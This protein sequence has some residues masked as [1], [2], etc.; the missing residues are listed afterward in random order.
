MTNSFHFINNSKSKKKRT[1]LRGLVHHWRFNGD[2]HDTIGEQNGTISFNGIFPPMVFSGKLYALFISDTNSTYVT[3]PAYKYFDD[4]PFTITSWLQILKLSSTN[5]PLYIFFSGDGISNNY[6]NVNVAINYDG[7]I[8]FYIGNDSSVVGLSITSNI[9]LQVRKWYYI[10][11][12]YDNGF[13][14]IYIN[15]KVTASTDTFPMPAT[16]ILIKYSLKINNF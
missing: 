8:T 4:K 1:K 6:N 2:L 11:C 12:T 15:G 14:D 16:G 3:L 7:S 9:S 5:D 10:V 13:G